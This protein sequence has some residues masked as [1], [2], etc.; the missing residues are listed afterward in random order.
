V[1]QIGPA[2]KSPEKELS[3]GSWDGKLPEVQGRKIPLTTPR[4]GALSNST[5]LD[6]RIVP[7]ST[8]AFVSIRQCYPDDGKQVDQV[9]FRM[10][11][12]YDTTIII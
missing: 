9:S 11:L 4:G 12:V 6:L 7:L 8:S 1:W 2:R 5:N 3:I 10:I